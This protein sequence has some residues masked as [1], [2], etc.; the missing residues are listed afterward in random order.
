MTEPHTSW[1]EIYDLAYEESFGDFYSALTETTIEQVMEIVEPPARIIDFGAGTGRLSIPLAACGFEVWA[2]EP[3]SAM[4]DQMHKKAGGEAI[5][6][7]TGRM[8]DFETD[9]PFDV[10]ICVFTVLLYLLDEESLRRSLKAAYDVLH[11]GGYLLFD[12]PS[13]G[14]FNGFQCETNLINR[15]V[16]VKPIHDDVYSYEENTA[17]TLDEDQKLYTDSFNI[18]YW[19]CD[20]VHQVLTEVGFHSIDELTANFIGTGSR[21]FMVQK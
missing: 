15:N 11:T 18:R 17:L 14:I 16:V 13:R 9:T 6:T 1:A 7:F 12:V 4:L 8:Q 19:S 20:K 21:Y 10:A 5:P 2:V 3:S